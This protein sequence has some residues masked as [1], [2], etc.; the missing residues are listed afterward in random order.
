MG[1]RWGRWYEGFEREEDKTAGVSL[2]NLPKPITVRM[3]ATMNEIKKLE[4]AAQRHLD[5]N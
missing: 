3:A 5:S 1:E 2:E 4:V